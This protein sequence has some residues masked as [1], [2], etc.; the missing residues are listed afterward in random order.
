MKDQRSNKDIVAMVKLT[1]RIP[2]HKANLAEDYNMIKEMYE[3]KHKD[4]LLRE[5]VEKKIK[6]TYVKISDDWKNCEFQYD[7]WIK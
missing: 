7:G 2:G 4:D 1:N 3:A 6:D 5:W